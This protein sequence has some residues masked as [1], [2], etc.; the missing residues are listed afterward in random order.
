MIYTMRDNKNYAL[1]KRNADQTFPRIPKIEKR[2]LER[3]S[4]FGR[5]DTQFD[6]AQADN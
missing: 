1:E 6:R 2:R 4:I 3:E 5:K